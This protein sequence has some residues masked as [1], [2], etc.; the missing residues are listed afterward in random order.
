MSIVNSNRLLNTLGN[1][2]KTD[3][4][5]DAHAYKNLTY[6]DIY[7]KYMGNKRFD[8]KVFVE[9]GVR[10]GASVRMWKEFF[11]NATIYGI[12]IDPR[13]I[14]FAEDRIKI[15][16]G[17]QND[18]NFLNELAKKFGKNIDIL[19]DDGSHI[20]KH[21][22]HTFEILYPC[23]KKNGLFIIEDLANSYEEW[24]NNEINLRQSWPGMIYNKPNDDLKNY[25]K[26]F[27]SFI[28][29]IVKNLD[30]HKFNKI[31]NDLISVHFYPMIVI[32]ENL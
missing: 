16:I 20:T 29:N 22:I 4:A 21:Q 11:P 26:D 13:C 1:K 9:I 12:D 28:N 2:Y 15:I 17:N 23:I 31:N 6:L 3:K 32:F 27:D 10:D 30:L 7:E 14:Q 18:K 19:L 24:G 25:R 5:D 8:V